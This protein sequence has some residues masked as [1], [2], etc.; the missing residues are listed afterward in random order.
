MCWD[1][2]AEMGR[3][4]TPRCEGWEERRTVTHER[5]ANSKSSRNTTCSK[6]LAASNEG[7]KEEKDGSAT[8]FRF[9]TPVR[10]EGRTGNDTDAPGRPTYHTVPLLFI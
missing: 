8:C 10:I 5:G 6:A 2:E 7:E 1:P 4:W 9:P 3:F